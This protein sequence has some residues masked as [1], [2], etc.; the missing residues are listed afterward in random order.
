MVLIFFFIYP[1]DGVLKKI[2]SPKIDH[3]PSEE[4]SRKKVPTTMGR[5]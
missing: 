2:N 5:R 3:S 4:R 1:S